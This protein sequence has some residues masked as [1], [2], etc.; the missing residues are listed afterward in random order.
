VASAPR[1]RAVPIGA[2]AWGMLLLVTG[3]IGL[4]DFPLAAV[5]AGVNVALGLVVRRIAAWPLRRPRATS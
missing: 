3:T 1:G 4:S 5:L 2:L